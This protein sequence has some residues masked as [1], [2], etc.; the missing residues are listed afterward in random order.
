MKALRRVLATTLSA[1]ALTA[2]LGIAPASATAGCATP[3]QLSG[4]VSVASQGVMTRTFQV[5]ATVATGGSGCLDGTWAYVLR[6]YSSNGDVLLT[7]DSRNAIQNTRSV[8]TSANLG[9]GTTSAVGNAVDS[10][11]VGVT[12]YHRASSTTTFWTEQDSAGWRV[13][14]P[15]DGFN[16]ATGD[17]AGPVAPQYCPA[18]VQ[19]SW[20]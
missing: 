6:A 1:L 3:T 5:G 10:I 2:G 17:D 7:L 15:N 4:S 9:T 13:V 8:G 11:T 12:A 16:T 20:C 18:H 19:S 14:V